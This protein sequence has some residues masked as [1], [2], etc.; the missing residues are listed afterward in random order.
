MSRH[1]LVFID[2][3]PE[4]KISVS[5]LPLYALR[6]YINETRQFV[7]G[8][9]E[10]LVYK[11]RPEYDA[12]LLLHDRALLFLLEQELAGRKAKKFKREPLP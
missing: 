8:L 4:P 2:E 6:N 5:Q 11:D 10:E 12:A 7:T 1:D 9:T 3:Y